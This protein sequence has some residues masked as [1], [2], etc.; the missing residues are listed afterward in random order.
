M[1]SIEWNFLNALCRPVDLSTMDNVHGASSG[2]TLKIYGE[3]TLSIITFLEHCTRL[4]IFT[5]IEPIYGTYVS[6]NDNKMFSFRMLSSPCTRTAQPHHNVPWEVYII[7][8]LKKTKR[9]PSCHLYGC[10]HGVDTST[11]AVHAMSPQW[12]INEQHS[13]SQL[14]FVANRI[15]SDK[16]CI[17]RRRNHQLWKGIIAKQHETRLIDKSKYSNRSNEHQAHRNGCVNFIG[18]KMLMILVIFLA[19]LFHVSNSQFLS[20]VQYPGICLSSHWRSI[21][22]CLYWRSLKTGNQLNWVIELLMAHNDFVCLTSDI[23]QSEL[24]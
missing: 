18:E 10:S 5:S 20:S 21:S 23:H 14:V 2:S 6:R 13:H 3:P 19:N 9:L 1:V 12:E 16:S 4:L 15:C 17:H 22:F 7:Y 11:M 8:K 24:R